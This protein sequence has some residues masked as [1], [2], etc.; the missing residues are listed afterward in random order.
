MWWIV[1]DPMFGDGR[2]TSGWR[3][4]HGS[5]ESSINGCVIGCAPS[6]SSSGSAVRPCTGNCWRWEPSLTLRER[7]RPTASLVAQ[8]RH[9]PQRRA[10]PELGGPAGTAPSLMT[11]TSR[12]ARCGPACR[13][14]WGATHKVAPYAD[15]LIRLR[16]VLRLAEVERRQ[17]DLRDFDLDAVRID[18]RCRALVVHHH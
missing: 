8:Q 2:Y 10:D 12:T 11:S 16:S 17:V 1:C 4:R 5:G 18:R 14:V 6:S 3:K 7:W 9:A 13:V 15:R